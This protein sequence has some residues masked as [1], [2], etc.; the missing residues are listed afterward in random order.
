MDV[1]R[2]LRLRRHRGEH[3]MDD[4]GLGWIVVPLFVYIVVWAARKA[5][6]HGGS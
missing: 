4:T 3:V 5:W 1:R 6:K 2:G